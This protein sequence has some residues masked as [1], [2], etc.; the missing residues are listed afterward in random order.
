SGKVEINSDGASSDVRDVSGDLKLAI[1]DGRARVIGFDGGLVASSEGGEMYLEGAFSSINATTAG[2]K[3]VLS[4]SP[5][6]NA[7]VISSTVPEV[8]S[9]R[10]ENIGENR[11][12]I[13]DGKAEYR[14]SS[15]G[16]ELVIRSADLLSVK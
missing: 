1:G 5:A 6:A 7:T 9:L 11:F 14:F 15:D 10:L 16:G 2:G 8:A 3:T 12:R 13:G 4:I